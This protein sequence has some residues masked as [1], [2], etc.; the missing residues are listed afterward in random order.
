[1]D[2]QRATESGGEVLE[3][4]AL[5]E[6]AREREGKPS[7]EPKEVRKSFDFAKGVLF[8]IFLSVICVMG[9]YLVTNGTVGAHVGEEK[10]LGAKVLTSRKTLEKLEEIEEQVEDTFL[11]EVDG[12]LL[13]S[14]LFQ[15]AAVGLNDPY[16]S[17]YTQQ[18]VQELLQESEG[19]YFG[20]GITLLYDEESDRVRVAGIY[21]GTPAWE[22][23]MQVDDEIIQVD[24]TRV[25]GLSLSEVVD[26]I[27]KKEGSV[28]V[29]VLRNGR[30]LSFA[31]EPKHVEIPTVEY[32]LLEEGIGL[33]KILEFD[34]ITVEQFQQALQDLSAQGAKKLIFDVRDNPGGVLDSV[35]EVL[36][37]LLPEGLIVSTQNKEGKRE[38]YSSDAEQLFTGPLAVLVNENS[39][40]AAEIFAGDI[41]DYDLGPLIGTKTY[42]KG[43]VQR[44]Y[45]LDDG[46]ALKLTTDKYLTAGEQDIDSRGIFPDIEVEQPK[47][48]KTLEEAQDD[49]GADSKVQSETQAQT[50]QEDLDPGEDTDLPLMRA[51]EYLRD[52]EG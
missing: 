31:M 29:T 43:V 3:E 34:S 12:E 9:I 30:R 47:E 39:A 24:E 27:K 51:I 52:Q 38:E 32:R 36:D 21:E 40:S 41:Q 49:T 5:E 25:D 14:M 33:L 10:D 28:T 18:E 17:Y 8:G 11:Y 42:G 7:E 1:M 37:F 4:E 6:T 45:L 13:S 35:C 20:I 15:G 26:R 2:E 50:G 23:G 44:T 22:A 46:S 48:S 19:E 16:A